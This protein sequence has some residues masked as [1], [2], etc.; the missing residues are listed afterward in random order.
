MLE[1]RSL[2]PKKADSFLS[3][4]DDGSVTVFCGKVDLGQ[5]L[6]IA[7]RQIAGEDTV[8]IA[9]DWMFV[10]S[11]EQQIGAININD[12][13]IAW[14]T[15][16]P[17]WYDAVKRKNTLTW[18][19]PLLVSDR[20]IVTGASKDALSLSPYTGE[21]LGHIELSEAAAPTVAVVADGTVL[22]ALPEGETRRGGERSLSDAERGEGERCPP[23]SP[24]PP[25]C[26]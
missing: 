15:Q 25:L 4:N 5:G 10:I 1:L 16:L 20:L 24:S 9:G 2:D 23:V 22:A 19:G 8:Y 21:I 3:V 14:I 13:R 6:R 7:I 26:A 11:A 12:G 17:R 18:Y